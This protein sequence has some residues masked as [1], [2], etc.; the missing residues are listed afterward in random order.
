MI[1]GPGDDQPMLYPK[2]ATALVEEEKAQLEKR[3][4]CDNLSEDT[5]AR[6]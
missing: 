6:I 5:V 1:L 3:R 2:V 4:S